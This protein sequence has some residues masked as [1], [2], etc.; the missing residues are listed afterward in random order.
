MGERVVGDQVRESPAVVRETV[1]MRVLLASTRGAGHFNPLV[2]FAEACRKHGH[3]VLIA[4]PLSLADAVDGA[5]F[6]FWRCADP[7]EDELA[8][9]WSRLP[10]LPPEEQ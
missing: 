6:R 2:P 8:Q 1:L 9:V 5:G 10:S 4:G 7:P 3:E